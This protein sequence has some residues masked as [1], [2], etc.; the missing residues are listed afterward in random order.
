MT[1]PHT[2]TDRGGYVTFGAK[3]LKTAIERL[4]KQISTLT[5]AVGA[6]GATMGQAGH[7]PVTVGTAPDQEDHGGLLD[8]A[9]GISY[10]TI[11]CHRDTWS[12]LVEQAARTEH[13]RLP[14]GIKEDEHGLIEADVSARTLLAAIDALR[15]AAH[16]ARASDITRALA[17][18]VHHRIGDALK[19][20]EPPA[21]GQSAVARIVIDDRPP[22]AALHP[23]GGAPA[24]PGPAGP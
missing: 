6:L 19:E 17:R 21:G 3:N 5:Q 12:F 9:A 11:V 10:A 20:L 16:D 4:E 1:S 22:R 18:R 23:A 14:A 8:R 13:F 24:H 15:Q 2:A 7:H